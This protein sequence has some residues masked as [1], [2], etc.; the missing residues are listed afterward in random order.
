MGN[1]SFYCGTLTDY[2]TLSDG[3]KLTVLL[4][5]Y[6]FST[7][8]DEP[9]VEIQL[10]TIGNFNI[11]KLKQYKD[12]CE[13]EF[14]LNSNSLVLSH[15]NVAEV[16]IPF[17]SYKVKI[18]DFELGDLKQKIVLAKELYDTESRLNAEL[19]K[20][21]K[22]VMS[23]VTKEL[24]TIEEKMQFFKDDSEKKA[25]FSKQKFLLNKI[26]NLVE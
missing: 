4:D 8:S 23:M 16:Q 3:I 11:P 7:E 10:D 18:V 9:K 21:I 2:T 20:K 15:H 22:A 14:T 25:A 24:I 5:E 13:A 6:V 1:D 12:I 17:G 19:N 26:Q